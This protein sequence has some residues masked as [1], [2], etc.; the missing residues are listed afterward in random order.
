MILVILHPTS[1]SHTVL[2]IELISGAGLQVLFSWGHWFE[3]KI[4]CSPHY[5]N[6]FSRSIFSDYDPIINW[7]CEC[8][9]IVDQESKQRTAFSMSTKHLSSPIALIIP[10]PSHTLRLILCFQTRVVVFSSHKYSR[11]F[12]F[13]LQSVH[14]LL[15][16]PIKLH[17]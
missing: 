2:A 10:E 12:Y 15:C 11:M 6:I 17:R 4:E 16:N 5:I 8:N 14:V 9:K 3:Y 1:D 13:E 7:G